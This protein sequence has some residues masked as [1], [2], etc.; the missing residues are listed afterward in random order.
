MGSRFRALMDE[1]NAEDGRPPPL[2]PSGGHRRFSA[3]MLLPPL[4]NCESCEDLWPS[5]VPRCLRVS[6]GGAEVPAAGPELCDFCSDASA[7]ADPEADPPSG[8]AAP[9]LSNFLF[10]SSFFFEPPVDGPGVEGAGDVPG[11]LG[12]CIWLLC[13]GGGGDMNC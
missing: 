11:I 5:A 10:T 2:G 7:A 4:E 13:E 3:S 6:D 9:V 8:F 12:G 1:A